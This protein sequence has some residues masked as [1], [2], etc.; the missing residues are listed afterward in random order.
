MAQHLL[1]RLVGAGLVLLAVSFITFVA[2]AT[3]PGDAASA[4]VGDSA[5]QEQMTLLRQSMGLDLPLFVRYQAYLGGVLQGDLGRSLV[6][7]RAVSQ[8]LLERL[9]YTLLLAVAAASLALLVGGMIG[10][11]AALRAGRWLDTVLMGGVAVGLA[12]PVFWSALLLMLLFSL[13]LHWL[14]VVGA[15]SWRHLILP[16][17]VLAIPTAAIVARLVRSS[18]LDVLA[19]DYVRTAQAK[20]LRPRRVLSAHVFR[21]SLLP[22]LTVVGLQL[23]HLLGGAVVVETIFGWPGLGRLTVQAIFDRDLPVVM[24]AALLIATFYVLLNLAIDL[25]HAYL[26]PRVAQEAL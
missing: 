14:P 26:D 22:V 19:A 1:R 7:N 24:G 15:S 5:S 9:P 10:T 8:L 25:A 3:A 13:K 6:G 16:M 2:L 12:V 18:L 11:V 23:G 21:N 20:G 4:L 17:V